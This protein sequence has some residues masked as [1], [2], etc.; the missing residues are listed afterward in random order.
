[1]VHQLPAPAAPTGPAILPHDPAPPTAVTLPLGGAA[2]A[3]LDECRHLA[4]VPLQ[5][6][7]VLDRIV[8]N[9]RAVAD[10]RPGS[11]MVLSRSAGDCVQLHVGGV[12]IASGEVIVIENTVGVRITD[13]GPAS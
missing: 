13:L 7:A 10:L 1:M 11:L 9:I 6:E 8:M 4:D 5:V 2:D 3:Q 12:P